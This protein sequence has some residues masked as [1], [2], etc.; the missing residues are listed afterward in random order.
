MDIKAL[1]MFLI[2]TLTFEI[3]AQENKWLPS[4]YRDLSFKEFVSVT[5]PLLRVKFF[6]KDEWVKDLKMGVYPASFSL[7]DVLDNLFL[8]T[9]IF[10]YIDKHGNVVLTKN[11]KVKISEISANRGASFLPP[12]DYTE[13]EEKCSVKLFLPQ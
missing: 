9:S 3:E 4:N 13:K 8:G 5:Q 6:Y 7:S 1:I 10:Y 12:S 11:F 2:L